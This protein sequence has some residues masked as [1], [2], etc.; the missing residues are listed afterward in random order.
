[1]RLRCRALW[2]AAGCALFLATPGRAVVPIRDSRYVVSI[3]DPPCDVVITPDNAATTLGQLNDAGTLVFC[4]DPGDYRAYTGH[5]IRTAGTAASPR[6]LRF[7]GP[8]ATKAFQRSP[9]AIFERL[10]IRASW[11]VIQGLTFRPQTAA[12]ERIVSLSG[13]DHVVVDGCLIDGIEHPNGAI[14]DGVVIVGNTGV[15]SADNTIQRNV[16][17]NGDQSHQAD[18]YGGVLVAPGFSPNED[19]DRNHVVDNEISDWGDGVAVAGTK[20]DCTDLGIQ[21]GTVIDNNDIYLTA[22]KYV[23]CTTGAADPNGECAC[24]ENGIDMKADPGPD[25]ADWT[26]VTNNRVWGYRPTTDAVVCGGSGALGQAISSGNACPGHVLVALN[27][28]SDS[29]IGIE[30]AGDA[31]IIASNLLHDIH[32]SNGNQWGTVAILTYDYATNLDIEWNTIVGASNSYDDRSMYTSTRCNTVV[33]SPETIGFGMPTGLGTATAYNYAYESGFYNFP[34]PTNVS[35]QSAAASQDQ[36]LCYARRRWTVPETVCVPYAA[37]TT[38]SP[39]ALAAG[40]CNKRVAAPFGIPSVSYW[41]NP[42]S[43][44]CGLGAE[45]SG[46]LP[47]LRWAARRRDV[48]RRPS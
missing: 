9:Q 3:P 47:L 32:P 35:Y 19:N 38:Q 20:A 17:R 14:Q 6:Y 12:T 4:V 26:V 27:A 31:W 10:D 13:V 11:W 43:T 36:T 16:I 33:L 39:H 46:V 42:P 21:H 28:V 5:V 22:A 34:G 30:A 2:S 7:H 15:P 41:N 24:A 44:S 40:N 45:V 18:D 8:G 1:M 48:A 37:T 25:A 29:T 23:D